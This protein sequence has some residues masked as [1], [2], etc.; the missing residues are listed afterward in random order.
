ML[1]KKSENKKNANYELK[2]NHLS[3]PIKKGEKVGEL[4][5]KV[6]GEKNRTI[7]LTVQNK[8]AKANLLEVYVHQVKSILA[9]NLN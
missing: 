8:V 7:P 5:L 9:G 2:A 3:A 4:I 1:N 6:E